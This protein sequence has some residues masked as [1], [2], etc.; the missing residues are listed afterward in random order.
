MRKVIVSL[1]KQP[2]SSAG[3]FWKYGKEQRRAASGPG[4]SLHYLAMNL[5]LLGPQLRAPTINNKD[6]V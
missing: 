3:S 2:R 5:G 6:N 4:M 1:K